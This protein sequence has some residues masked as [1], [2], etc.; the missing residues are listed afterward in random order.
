MR[1]LKKIIMLVLC[2]VA[3]AHTHDTSM[4]YLQNRL[5]VEVEKTIIASAADWDILLT[6]N[7]RIGGAVVSVKETKNWNAY[8][9]GFKI[10]EWEFFET[11]G[12]TKHAQA[13]KRNNMMRNCLGCGGL[14]LIPLGV[15]LMGLGS[16]WFTAG[17]EWFIESYNSQGEGNEFLII[18]GMSAIGVGVV[19]PIIGF[20]RP[21]KIFTASFAVEVADAY[22]RR[23]LRSLE[24]Q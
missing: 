10:S 3:Y 20:S 24:K 23:L 19:L 1:D 9:G 12:F 16:K 2:F 22:N 18:S 14:S 13:S 5:A 6:N 17:P 7:W 15:L 11:A 8:C 21:K 4:L